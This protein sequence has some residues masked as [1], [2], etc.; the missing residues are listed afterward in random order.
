M[1]HRRMPKPSE[2]LPLLRPAP[3]RWD[4]TERRL[5]RAAN[6]ADLREIARRRTPRAVFDYT[7]GAADGE[8]SL[9]RARQAFS[10]VEFTPS[11]LRDVSEIE[12]GRTILGK[13]STLPFAFAPT[14]FTRMM[15][16][17]GESAVAAVA[18]EVG[19]PFTL[20]TMGTTTIEQIVDIAPD[21]RRW[22]QLYLWRD[23]AYAKDL[24]QRAADAGYD[25]LMLTVDTP[26]G[27]ARLRDVRNGLT[28]PPA[29][30]LRTF[31]DGARHPHWWFDMFTTEPLAF[32]N[33][34]GTDG[35]IAEMINRVFDPA[36]TMADVEWLRGAWPGTLVVKG[37]QSVAD[38]RR[39]VD[40]G[41]DAVL[42]SNHGG[43]QLDRAP[44]PLE[45][46]EPTVAELRGE[47]EVLVDTGITHGA[48]IVAAI[49]LGANAALVGRAYLYGLMAGGKR[50]VEKVVQILRGEIE[51]TLALMGVTRVDD[52]RPEHVRIRPYG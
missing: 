8:L 6:I 48:D 10:R 19:I 18:Q 5:A 50:G 39:V 4:A 47:A 52:L 25:T 9:R 35:T 34:E 42:L 2:I 29:L 46:I 33:L 36:L 28:I 7:D 1:V 51:R 32:S 24:V 45:L 20:S 26:V 44:V 13:R 37:I 38:A 3:I 30:S 40:A 31:L 21:V 16:T 11:V 49:A 12:T 23:R 22:F 41:A 43:R 27:G 17:E 14:G 15:H